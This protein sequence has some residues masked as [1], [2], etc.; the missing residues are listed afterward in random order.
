[1][2][3]FSPAVIAEAVIEAGLLP[4]STQ[5]LERLALYGNLLLKWNS[6]MNL[7]AIRDARGILDRHIVESVA[8]AEF[9]PAGV[10]TLLDY[11]SGAGLPGVP[12]AVCREEIAVTLAESQ[13]KKAA[14]LAEVS[15]SVGVPMRVH[16][17]R[18]NGLPRE[19]RYDVVALRAVDKMEGAVREARNRVARGGSLLFFATPSTRDA[20]LEAADAASVIEKSISVHGS[21]FL[22][23]V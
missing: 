10:R 1:M 12:I 19:S 18:V 16:A 21:I 13:S 22:C 6:R 9:V 7:S 2:I 11:G 4:L 20:L 23:Q 14:F 8:A 5:A 17:G 15:R 3:A